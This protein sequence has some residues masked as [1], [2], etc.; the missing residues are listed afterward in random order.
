MAFARA[1]HSLLGCLRRKYAKRVA[2]LRPTP[3]NLANSATNLP[4]DGMESSMWF[5]QNPTILKCRFSFL[6]TP[7]FLYTHL[8]K[9]RSIGLANV[10]CIP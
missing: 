9:N 10:S 4:K 3:G 8:K 1:S 2:V 5:F 6:K 7:K